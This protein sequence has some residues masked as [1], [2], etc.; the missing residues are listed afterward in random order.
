M[1]I[2]LFFQK[3]LPIC[4]IVVESMGDSGWVDACKAQVFAFSPCNLMYACRHLK[5]QGRALLVYTHTGGICPRVVSEQ[6][7]HA[8]KMDH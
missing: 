2:A 3:P 8:S 7:L 5:A 6:P 4:S 1:P